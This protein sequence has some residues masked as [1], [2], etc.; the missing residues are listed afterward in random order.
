MSDYDDDDYSDQRYREEM[1]YNRDYERDYFL[2]F[3][4]YYDN[5]EEE[6]MEVALEMYGRNSQAYRSASNAYRYRGGRAISTYEYRRT[7][8]NQVTV[9]LPS[10][11]DQGSVSEGKLILTWILE[12]RFGTVSALAQIIVSY[13]DDQRIEEVFDNLEKLRLT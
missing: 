10:P 4:G 6:D 2:L 12:E 7:F 1:E 13:V 9:P 5:Q 11:I 3:N 8:S